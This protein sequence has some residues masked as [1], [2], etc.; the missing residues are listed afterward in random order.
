MTNRGAAQQ[1]ADL[2]PVLEV[3]Y[4]IVAIL[5]WALEQ[6]CLETV[7]HSLS[8]HQPECLQWEEA[9]WALWMRSGSYLCVI[10]R[11]WPDARF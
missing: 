4:H 2:V 3:W 10:R 9:R 5:S 7:W 8:Q 11:R 6:V 1:C